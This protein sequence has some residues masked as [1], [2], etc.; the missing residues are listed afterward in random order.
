[1]P[2]DCER[3]GDAGRGGNL[4]ERLVE[5]WLACDERVGV[6]CWLSSVVGV[7]GLLVPPARFDWPLNRALL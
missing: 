3:D 4:E 5:D 2:I 1:M 6:V 7:V